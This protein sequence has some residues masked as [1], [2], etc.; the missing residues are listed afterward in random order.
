LSERLGFEVDVPEMTLSSKAAELGA[1]GA[2]GASDSTMEI[3]EYLIAVYPASANGYWQLANLHREMGDRE[4]A[5]AYYRKCLEI[6]PNMRPARDWI[7]KLEA[8]K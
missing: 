6:I 2:T 1:S 8:Q 3:L 7:E 4:A 5:I